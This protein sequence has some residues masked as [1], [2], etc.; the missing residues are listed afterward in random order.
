MIKKS[1]VIRKQYLNW[2]L[3]PVKFY[4]HGNN[5]SVLTVY[6]FC[7]T[8]YICISYSGVTWKEKVHF[9]L[10]KKKRPPF[11]EN[12]FCTTHS[13]RPFSCIPSFYLYN[14]SRKNKACISHCTE[15]ETDIK[16]HWVSHPRS[17][18]VAELRF[19]TALC[20]CIAHS[21]LRMP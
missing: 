15:E 1:S 19:Q 11:K 16:P 12:W 17:H 10:K 2:Y 7:I 14:A 20:V 4:L 6:W 21:L 5:R 3:T 18:T 9:D 13:A 8:V